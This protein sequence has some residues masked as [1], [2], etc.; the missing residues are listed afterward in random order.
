MSDTASLP[1]ELERVRGEIEQADRALVG[2]IAHRVALARRVGRLKRIA[3]L[4]T[5]D[6]PREAAVAR[7]GAALAREAGLPEE[8]MR[9]LFWHLIH[10]CRS[11]QHDESGSPGGRCTGELR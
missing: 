5:L 2:L 9:D 11:A 10:L 1:A 4:P 6:P 3:A 7:R 8:R